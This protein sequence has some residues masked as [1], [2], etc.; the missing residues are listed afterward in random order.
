MNAQEGFVSH[1]ME[2]RSRLIRA[3]V[4][5]VVVFLCLFPLLRISTIFWLLR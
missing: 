5:V 1:L 2:L 3:L 4:A